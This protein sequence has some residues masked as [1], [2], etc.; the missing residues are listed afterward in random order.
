MRERGTAV[1][2]PMWVWEPAR[3][4]AWGGVVKE[5]D[6]VVGGRPH[7]NGAHVSYALVRVYQHCHTEWLR[8]E[9]RSQRVILPSHRL[10]CS[11]PPAHPMLSHGHPM[12]TSDRTR[13]SEREGLFVHRRRPGLLHVHTRGR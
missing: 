4:T 3:R 5:R 7:H 1:G 12:H 9:A 8:W 10:R 13:A 2:T 11:P 6:V